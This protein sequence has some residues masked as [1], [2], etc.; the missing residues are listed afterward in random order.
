LGFRDGSPKVYALLG[1][2]ISARVLPRLPFSDAASPPVSKGWELILFPARR[3]IY[4]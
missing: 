1:F 3:G 4:R 2:W